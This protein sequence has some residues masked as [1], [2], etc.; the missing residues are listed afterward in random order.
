MFHTLIQPLDSED[1]SDRYPPLIYQSLPNE[2]SFIAKGYVYQD[3][4]AEDGY[5]RHGECNILHLDS[6]GG[7]I[8]A[9]KQIFVELGDKI[10]SIHRIFKAS[11]IAIM[12]WFKF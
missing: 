11:Y 2:S 4:F 12:G 7:F 9:Y 8:G 6:H 1:D 5:A 3:H 10:F